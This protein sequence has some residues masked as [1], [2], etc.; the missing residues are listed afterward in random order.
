MKYTLSKISF[1]T[2]FKVIL[3][4][5]I[6]YFLFLLT[7]ISMQ[8]KDNSDVGRYQFHTDNPYLLDTKTGVIKRYPRP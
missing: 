7:K 8:L 2:L 3:L 4:V 5:F 6:A 1:D